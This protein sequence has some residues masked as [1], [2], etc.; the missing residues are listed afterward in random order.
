MQDD[1]NI[2]NP[3]FMF[4]RKAC[5]KPLGGLCAVLPIISLSELEILF[6]TACIFILFLYLLYCQQNPLLNFL[7]ILL[8]MVFYFVKMLA[9]ILKICYNYLDLSYKQGVG[10][11]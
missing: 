1:G 10:L 6:R 7:Y 2:C 8:Y 3:N 11:L 9:I 5:A 4:G